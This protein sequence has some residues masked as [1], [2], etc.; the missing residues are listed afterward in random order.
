[1]QDRA[2]FH[3]RMTDFFLFHHLEALPHA[4]PKSAGAGHEFASVGWPRT[5][6]N[7]FWRVT[8]W[9]RGAV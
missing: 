9:F 2:K 8:G 3:S 1:M 5:K 7:L 4:R 6:V